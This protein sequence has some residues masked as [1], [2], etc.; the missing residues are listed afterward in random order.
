MKLDLISFYIM[1]QN[2]PLR[3]ETYWWFSYPFEKYKLN[4]CTETIEK[5]LFY[6][7]SNLTND[8]IETVIALCNYSGSKVDLNKTQCILLG[9]LK[10]T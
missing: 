8:E 10:D 9:K 2:S 4:I 7:K 6:F 3:V 1:H 5:Y